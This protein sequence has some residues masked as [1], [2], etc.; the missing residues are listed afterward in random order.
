MTNKLCLNAVITLCAILI[1]GRGVRTAHA[2]SF[3]FST[4][5]AST[6]AIDVTNGLP[7]STIGLD[8]STISGVN[9]PGTFNQTLHF[10]SGYDAVGGPVGFSLV[11]SVTVTNES[12]LVSETQTITIFGQE[13][14]SPTNDPDTGQIFAGPSYLFN[15]L[16]VYFT[17]EALTFLDNPPFPGGNYTGSFAADITRAPV[18]ASSVPEPATYGF[19]A[20]GIA[21]LVSRRAFRRSGA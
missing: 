6:V 3:S 10:F 21:G 7:A 8:G 18:T 2:A 19:V 4:T 1:T 5:G 12:T 13:I 20:L 11:E 14:V 17:P 16:G 15:T 9:A